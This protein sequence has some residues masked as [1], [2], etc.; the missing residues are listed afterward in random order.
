MAKKKKSKIAGKA[1]AKAKH[2]KKANKGT[3]PQSKRGGKGGR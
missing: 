1:A 3:K 2:D